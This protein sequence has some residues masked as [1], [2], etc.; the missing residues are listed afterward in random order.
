MT[1]RSEEF[2]YDI[3]IDEKELESN[4]V[5]LKERKRQLV[6]NTAKITSQVLFQI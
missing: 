6:N 5:P 2:D 4:Y 3:D 1:K